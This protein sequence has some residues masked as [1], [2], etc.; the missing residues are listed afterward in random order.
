LRYLREFGAKD[1][2]EGNLVT[3]TLTKRF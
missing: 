1:R 3:L 2:P